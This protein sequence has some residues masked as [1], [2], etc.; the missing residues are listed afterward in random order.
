[1]SPTV[2]YKL[3]T[4][5]VRAVASDD[6]GTATGPAQLAEIARGVLDGLDADQEHFILFA[7]N[8]RNKVTGYKHLF[9]GSQD[10][11]AVYP[12][13]VMR[14]ALNLGAV[15]LAMVHNHP[16]GEVSPSGEDRALCRRMVQAARTIDLRLMDSLVIGSQG[17]YYS[18]SEAG[19]L[20]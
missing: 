6:H 12:A 14:A 10:Q 8:S 15:G 16:S 18:A 1:M 19:E 9:S 2:C 7:M 3:R 5:Q 13:M 17:R 20:S 4:F 11:C